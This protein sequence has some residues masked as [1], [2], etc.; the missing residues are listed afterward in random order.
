MMVGSRAMPR[1]SHLIEGVAMTSDIV[2]RLAALA[3]MQAHIVANQLHDICI[4][5]VSAAE[6]RFAA[7]LA[8]RLEQGAL[9]ADEVIHY[10]ERLGDL[11]GRQIDNG[12]HV[13]W[14]DDEN[15]VRGGYREVYREVDASLLAG[16][17]LELDLLADM[18]L[19]TLSA[20]RA[21]RNTEDE[22]DS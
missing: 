22:I 2:T 1:L 21:L 18:I 15:H 3:F 7:K 6:R 12:T 14:Q 11:L 13:F 5:R 8:A 9:F 17:A 16:V 19:G 10:L 4:P 20:A